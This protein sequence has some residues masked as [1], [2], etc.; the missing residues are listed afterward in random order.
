MLASWQRG[1]GQTHYKRGVV[2]S[3]TAAHHAIVAHHA[4]V[5]HAGHVPA[6]HHA[7]ATGAAPLV[8]VSPI[9]GTFLELEPWFLLLLLQLQDN[10]VLALLP[11]KLDT[12]D[13]RKEA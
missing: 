6:A 4:A 8:V 2:L 9:A 3:A 7:T 12:V 11:V 13:L 1:V 10:C 5:H